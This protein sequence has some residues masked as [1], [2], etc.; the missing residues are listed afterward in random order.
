MNIFLI[1][2]GGV[3]WFLLLE[4]WGLEKEICCIFLVENCF[5]FMYW[6]CSCFGSVLFFIGVGILIIV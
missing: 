1:D 5:G 6:S 2:Y 4:V 3:S